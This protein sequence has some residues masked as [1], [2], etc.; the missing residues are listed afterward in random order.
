M[1]ADA[2]PIDS[3]GIEIKVNIKNIE[4]EEY[5]GILKIY[6]VEI[7]SRWRN[8]AGEPYHFA[9]LDLA[10]NKNFTIHSYENYNISVIWK[11]NW[12]VS[13]DN[14]VFFIIVFNQ[15]KH[16]GYSDPPENNRSFIAYYPDNI[17]VAPINKLLIKITKPLEGYIYVFNR[18]TF[19]LPTRK[20]IVIG[21]ITMVA[22]VIGRAN[23]VE[24]YIVEGG[25]ERKIANFSTPPYEVIVDE[26]TGLY[27]L[28]AIAYGE[29]TVTDSCRLL[30]INFDS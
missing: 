11:N 5:K 24:F 15:E 7:N 20:A 22:S 16:I 30:I 9:F 6:A 4:K 23:K 27:S 26:K 10:I 29:E 8:S 25:K 12:D 14:L 1:Y 21:K 28:K 3:K 2:K 17:A 13:L 18:E 19:K